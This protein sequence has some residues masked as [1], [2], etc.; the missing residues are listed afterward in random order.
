MKQRKLH[1]HTQIHTPVCWRPFLISRSHEQWTKK[2][3]FLPWMRR[4][5][6]SSIGNRSG[7]LMFIKEFLARCEYECMWF[8]GVAIMAWAKSQTKRTNLYMY[9]VCTFDVSAPTIIR[10]CS[11]PN[12]STFNRVAWMARAR[13]FG[14]VFQTRIR[15]Y[16][17]GIDAEG[18]QEKRGGLNWIGMGSSRE[19]MST[20]R[21]G[22]D[23]SN[24][25]ISVGLAVQL[26]L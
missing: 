24:F 18:V 11:T 13:V 3:V 12:Y 19:Y 5:R 16:I 17:T 8:K 4:R 25:Q 14:P 2:L 15:N 7:W 20:Y 1:K 10:G 6:P 26:T 22:G 9:E 21:G 23:L